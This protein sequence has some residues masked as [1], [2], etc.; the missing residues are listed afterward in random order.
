MHRVVSY[1]EHVRC[2]ALTIILLQYNHWSNPAAN[3]FYFKVNRRADSFP[4]AEDYSG[5][6]RTEGAAKPSR[7]SVW[8]SND[9]L[10]MS[11]HPKV[12]EAIR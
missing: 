5:V 8:C 11:R 2:Y 12:L 1:C 7:I 4:F 10:G 6:E 3:T 9:Y